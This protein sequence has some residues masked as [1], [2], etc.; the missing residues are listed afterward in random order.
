MFILM[1]PSLL[2]AQAVLSCFLTLISNTA[3]L[4]RLAFLLL[5]C[6]RFFLPSAASSASPLLLILFLPTLG[7]PSPFYLPFPLHTLL[8]AT[9]RT[10]YS[11]FL[12][13]TKQFV[14]AGYP[15]M[16]EFLVMMLLT[17][18]HMT[19]S[20]F[21]PFALPPFLFLII[22]QFFGLSFIPAGNLSG[23][24][25]LLINFALSSPQFPLG[26]THL[27]LPDAGRLP[28]PAYELATPDSPILT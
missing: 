25:L 9:S 13:V 14:S 20:P 6:L 22:S 1:A 16:L 12:P 28:W 23:P 18:W 24:P 17:L 8:S 5:S 2:L 3:S 21:L 15:V 19:P 27:I 10:G 7:R 26:L 4:W 11:A